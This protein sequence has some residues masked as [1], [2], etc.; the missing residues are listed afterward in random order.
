MP[1]LQLVITHH[2]ETNVQT[3]PGAASI[4]AAVWFVC[5]RLQLLKRSGANFPGNLSVHSN[6]VA[7]APKR[8]RCLIFRFPTRSDYVVLQ[9]FAGF[10][11]YDWT[12]RENTAAD[13]AQPQ[14]R[15]LSEGLA[16]QIFHYPADATLRV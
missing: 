6:R 11:D 16:G 7:N 2:A 12:R 15:Q 5:E 13:L 3:K 4:F 8:Q 14:Q 1:L 9:R 10:L